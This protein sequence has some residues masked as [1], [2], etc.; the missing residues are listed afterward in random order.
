MVKR[1]GALFGSPFISRC[2]ISTAL[3]FALIAPPAIARTIAHSTSHAARSHKDTPKAHPDTR[4]PHHR[5]AR[6]QKPSVNRHLTEVNNGPAA[7]PHRTAGKASRP[8]ADERPLIVIDPGH[9]GKDSGAVGVAGTLEKNVALSAAEELKRLLQ[10]TGRYRVAMTRTKDVFVSLAGRVAFA[11]THQAALMI[12]IHANSSKNHGAH[13]ASVWVRSGQT[14]GEGVTHL[15]AGSRDRT[16]IADALAGG[17]PHPSPGSAWLQYTMIDNLSGD[18]R[19]EPVP[20]RQARFYV[21]GLHDVPS[22]LLEMGYLSNR[23]DEVL[24]NQSK[25]RRVMT[26]AIR[27]AVE[28]YFNKL[29]H[30][31]AMRT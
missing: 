6:P 11:R 20:A 10:A 26:E 17:P 4:R 28:D 27:D 19:M 15:P 25:F 7:S 8:T 1:Y 30:P 21:L 13:G 12:A 5:K 29:A 14:G 3:S 9:G 23:R 2:L 16:E 24:L 31:N 18:V 22:V